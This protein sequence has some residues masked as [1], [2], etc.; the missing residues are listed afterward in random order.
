MNLSP[1]LRLRV[2]LFSIFW[3]SI[4]SACM[5]ASSW[6]TDA[7]LKQLQARQ[8]PVTSVV[9]RGNTI[10]IS[11]TY[12]IESNRLPEPR[13]NADVRTIVKTLCDYPNVGPLVI[14]FTDG[15]Y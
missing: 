2:G 5:S 4:L 7:V 3:I 10:V 12:G 8:V 13:A 14:E 9:V 6:N 15:M 11:M 1:A